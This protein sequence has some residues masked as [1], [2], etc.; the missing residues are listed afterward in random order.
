MKRHG[1]A[2][3]V[4]AASVALTATAS[5]EV[6]GSER[7]GPAAGD[8]IARMTIDDVMLLSKAGISDSLIIFM[9]ESSGSTFQLTT[10]DVIDLARAGVPEDVI[11]QMVSSRTEQA[12]AAEGGYISDEPYWYG[13]A[14]PY[15]DPWF[16]SPLW[17]G[18][19]VIYSY[20]A[21]AAVSVAP[22]FRDNR[23]YNA[24]GWGQGGGRVFGGFRGGGHRR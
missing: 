6:G 8:T 4:V 16:W 3:L 10:H 1:F 9:I 20:P 24:V 17:V 21:Y 14:Y 23:V 7:D 13:V 2:A 5:A 19:G 22:E 12:E 15:W 11:E 18:Y